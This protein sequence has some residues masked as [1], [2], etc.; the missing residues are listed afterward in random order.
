MHSHPTLLKKINEFLPRR[1]LKSLPREIV[2]VEITKRKSRNINRAYRKKNKPANV[3]SFRYGVRYGEIL[4]CPD[5]IRTE[6]RASGSS[7]AR[8]RA[9]MVVHGVLHLA[10]MHHEKSEIISRKAEKIEQRI[11]Q[12]IFGK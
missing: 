10:G 4:I 11:L 5:I 8:Q 9:W 2:V 6:A 7:Y 12:K 3:L 1:I